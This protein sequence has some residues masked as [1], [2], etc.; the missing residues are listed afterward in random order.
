MV[1]LRAASIPSAVGGEHQE[2]VVGADEDA[3]VG[4]ADRDRP[5]LAADARIDDREVHRRRH[6]GDG[7]CEHERTLGHRL[8]RDPVA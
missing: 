4:R 2:A 6:V 3:A 8:R 1:R 5:P 7:A